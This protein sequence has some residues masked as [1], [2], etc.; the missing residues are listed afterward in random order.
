MIRKAA[1]LR[2]SVAPPQESGSDRS[3]SPH[4]VY[5]LVFVFALAL[6]FVFALALVFVFALALVFVFE[7]SEDQ[8]PRPKS[9]DRIQASGVTLP[10]I[11]S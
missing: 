5:A 10:T 2:R 3:H 9:P 11:N 7:C 8:W 6:V 4:N 1:V